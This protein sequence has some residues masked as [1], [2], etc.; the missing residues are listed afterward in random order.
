MQLNRSNTVT[1]IWYGK[2]SKISKKKK[3]NYFCSGML[4]RIANR[5]DP[6]QTASS[7]LSLPFV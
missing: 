2:C 6:E 5:K 4:A 3:K 7:D 1:I